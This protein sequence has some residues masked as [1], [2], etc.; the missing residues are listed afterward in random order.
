[1]RQTLDLILVRDNRFEFGEEIAEGD[2]IHSDGS[3]EMEIAKK[4]FPML[5]FKRFTSHGFQN[6][7]DSTELVQLFGEDHDHGGVD[8]D[9]ER[10]K[11]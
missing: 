4:H 1:M 11:M 5:F 7:V 10:K 3:F 6:G 9:L 8:R 2:V